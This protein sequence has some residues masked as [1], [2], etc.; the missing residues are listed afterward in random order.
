MHES[1]PR[2]PVPAALAHRMS[3][4]ITHTS[5]GP[6]SPSGGGRADPAPPDTAPK[7]P[8]RPRDSAAPS[9]PAAAPPR[10]CPALGGPGVATVR[11][12]FVTHAIPNTSS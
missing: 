12:G 4:G 3:P 9:S 6:P 1:G 8:A 11:S 2:S 5:P 7:V 10:K